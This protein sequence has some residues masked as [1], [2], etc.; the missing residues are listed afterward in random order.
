MR[1]LKLIYI[2]VLTF[3]LSVEVAAIPAKP[4]TYK[5]TQPDGSTFSA[6]LRGDEYYHTLTTEDGCSVI[7]DPSGWYCYAR[8]NFS[9]DIESSGVRV[10]ASAPASVL[11]AAR[12]IPHTAVRAKALASRR[13]DFR[14]RAAIASGTKATPKSRKAII[15]LV[16]FADVKFRDSEQKTVSK[17]ENLLNGS[18]NKSAIEYFNDQ[19]RGE[20]Q[21]QFVV[22]KVVTLPEKLEYYGQNKGREIDIHAA[23]GVAQA[24][25]AIDSEVD[26]SQFDSDGDGYV[27][28]VFVFA[29]GHSEAE[30][31]PASAIWPHQFGVEEGTGEQ[32]KLDGVFIDNYAIATELR[33]GPLSTEF[34]T[35]GTFCHEYSHTLGVVD[36]YDTDYEGSE[37]RSSGLYG[38]SIM[39]TGSYNDDGRTPPCY[40]AVEMWQLG[41]GQA[42]PITETGLYSLK[43]LSQEKKYFWIPTDS[44]ME[45]YL[46]ECR[47]SEEW[48]RFLGGSGLIIYHIDISERKA[49]YSETYEM[50]MTYQTRW[51]YNEVNACPSFMAAKV[52]SARPG[53]SSVSQVFWPGANATVFGAS[54]N[55]AFVYH[56]GA[57]PAISIRD[58]K[59]DRNGVSFSVTGPVTIKKTEVF[60]DACIVNWNCQIGS[61]EPCIISWTGAYGSGRAEVKPYASSEYSYTIEGLSEKSDYEI[62]VYPKSSPSDGA[63][64]TITTKNYYS[65]GYPFIY[66]GS[67]DRNPDGSFS[68][69][70]RTPLRVYN[71]RGATE[72]RWF[73]DSAP[74]SVEEDGYYTIQKGGDL[75]AVVYYF[76]GKKESIVKKIKIR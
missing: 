64:T 15:I 67:T 12:S 25:K 6:Q 2:A 4:G 32:L 63:V 20:W 13:R 48:D 49:G 57:S 41:I 10:G 27:D 22:S 46:L 33:G 30:G 24:C 70:T 23:E 55:P 43:P 71:A 11:A 56:S 5:Y 42:Q 21:F 29:A 17:F 31:A 50:E 53:A 62:R 75:K 69:G 34:T 65:S 16:Q 51:W 1:Y 52:E 72:V 60:Q 9:G 39:D 76:D 26:F 54:T 44:D 74:I 66:L 38:L 73:L 59:K 7:L 14:P 37:G 19:F 47:D 28:N 18:G 45:F 8:Y 58:I 36:L 61:D 68:R 35:I 3:V 40:T